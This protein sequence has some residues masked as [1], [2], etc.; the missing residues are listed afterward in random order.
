[1]LP[2]C[3][4]VLD[5]Q[6]RFFF[7]FLHI[8]K[9]D[10]SVAELI[11]DKLHYDDAGTTR[12]ASVYWSCDKEMRCSLTANQSPENTKDGAIN[13]WRHSGYRLCFKY[14]RDAKSM[15][16]TLPQPH[17]WDLQKATMVL[18][19]KLKAFKGSVCSFLHG[20]YVLVSTLWRERRFVVYLSLK[21][22]SLEAHFTSQTISFILFFLLASPDSSLLL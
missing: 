21:Q 9:R 10:W 20:G 13:Q 14:N 3:S 7:L 5:K 4:K 12:D 22:S 6:R 19:I 2:V 11:L 8:L 18:E 17:T 16:R 1:M 15:M